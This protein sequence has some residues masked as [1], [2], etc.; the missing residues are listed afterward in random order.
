MAEIL[1]GVVSCGFSPIGCLI[2]AGQSLTDAY[3]PYT[4]WPT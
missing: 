2:L 3:L 4:L 1:E